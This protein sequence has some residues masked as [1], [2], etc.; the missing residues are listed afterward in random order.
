MPSKKKT[1]TK[2]PRSIEEDTS[3]VPV[4]LAEAVVS[5]AEILLGIKL[6]SDLD[7]WLAGYAEA[8]YANNERFRKKVQSNADHG[9]AGRDYLYAFMCHWLSSEILK[10]TMH[11][12]DHPRIRETLMQSGFSMGHHDLMRNIEPWP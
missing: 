11:D 5:D 1:T 7:E 6:P 3:I 2:L 10:R 8:V 12:D 9:N 4:L